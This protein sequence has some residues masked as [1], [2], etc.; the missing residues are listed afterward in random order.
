M[1]PFSVQ[2]AINGEP[3][4]C[5]SEE[6]EAK[7]GA[8]NPEADASCRIAVWWR[9]V[10]A[11]VWQIGGGHRED[12]RYLR[13]KEDGFDLFMAPKKRVVW[14]R[15]YSTGPNENAVPSAM[16]AAYEGAPCI[17]DGWWT[18]SYRWLGPAFPVEIE[19]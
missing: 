15:L 2:T 4:R 8:Y 19:E 14:V 3:I 16:T 5:R 13:D 1:K 10:G 17:Q 11:S 6:Y 12:G 9:R 18:H 7:F